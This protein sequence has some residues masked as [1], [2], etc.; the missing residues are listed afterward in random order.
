MEFKKP[1]AK[2]AAG[3][4][5]FSTSTISDALEKFGP[6]ALDMLEAIAADKTVEWYPRAVVCR[7]MM[8]MCK[9]AILRS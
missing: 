3:F 6:A 9:L 7:V 8:T 1:D 2:L 4:A 5:R